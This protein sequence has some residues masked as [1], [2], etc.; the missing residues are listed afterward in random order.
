MALSFL[1]AQKHCL[2]QPSS[3]LHP[4]VRSPPIIGCAP[5]AVLTIS[6]S[7]ELLIWAGLELKTS[8]NR[9]FPGL[10]AR[11]SLLTST[12][13][14]WTTTSEPA[15]LSVLVQ[16][17]WRPKEGLCERFPLPFKHGDQSLEVRNVEG[18]IETL[19]Y[20]RHLR[21]AQVRERKHQEKHCDPNAFHYLGRIQKDDLVS[22]VS[23]VVRY[24][25]QMG[26]RFPESSSHSTT[27]EL[28]ADSRPCCSSTL[29]PSSTYPTFLYTLTVHSSHIN[30]SPPSP[31]SKCL[32]SFLSS[33][34][35]SSQPQANQ[36]ILL[37]SVDLLSEC[38]E[39]LFCSRC[40]GLC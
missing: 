40:L 32:F 7:R 16:L 13:R 18:A 22:R 31:S 2:P 10:R 3:I 1:L 34:W 14:T 9:Y 23:H 20:P 8:W 25:R 26:G 35:L 27:T 37:W 24:L 15:H 33:L 29:S 4:L 38:S 17:T 11:D 36:P 30:A 5:V 19:L 21:C 39:T 6:L 28:N 12:T